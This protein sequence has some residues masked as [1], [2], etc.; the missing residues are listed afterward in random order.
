MILSWP[1]IHKT[2]D[3]EPEIHKALTGNPFNLVLTWIAA[4]LVQSPENSF[5]ES[6]GA[7]ITLKTFFI[8]N[9]HISKDCGGSVGC[10][11]NLLIFVVLFV[12]SKHTVSYSEDNPIFYIS[13]P[14]RFHTLGLCILR[15]HIIFSLVS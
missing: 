10:K 5:W 4:L 2:V 11:P 9:F 7:V 12:P 8:L 15:N 1:Q 6:V 13:T 3:L 14:L